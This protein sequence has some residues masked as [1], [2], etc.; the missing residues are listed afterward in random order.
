MRSGKAITALCLDIRRATIEDK[1]PV[2]LRVTYKGERRYYAT[3][4]HLSKD[5]WKSYKGG[6]NRGKLKE[7]R[8]EQPAILNKANNVIEIIEDK[9]EN[10]A[11]S[12]FNDLYFRK[13]EARGGVLE[14]F[15]AYIG[16]FK[17]QGKI[18][19]AQ[20]YQTAKASLETFINKKRI[21]F[22]DITPQLLKSYEKSVVDSG[23]SRSTVGVYLRNLRTIFNKAIQDGVV[24]QEHYPFGHRKY[25]IPSSEA[26]EKALS[27]DVLSILYTY[28]GD[29]TTNEAL[30]KD[31]WFFIYYCN[32]MNVKDVCRLK[33]RNIVRD[34]LSFIRAKTE[35]SVNRV[36]PII[37]PLNEEIT[38]IIGKWGNKPAHPDYYI[39]PFYS[40]VI[41]PEEERRISQN[42]TKM[43]NNHMKKIVKKLEL[44]FDITTYS[45]RHSHSNILNLEGAPTRLI[46]DNLGH[47][48]IHTTEKHYLAAFD[49]ETK[50]K[51]SD[52]LLFFKQKS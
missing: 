17:E 29:E 44:D 14:A 12:R 11:F 37:V 27:K 51:Y 1:Y 31:I 19:S 47:S 24:Q 15:E 13:Q 36:R 25:I 10:F 26:R 16:Q 20:S 35:N 21:A 52:S 23:K 7:L 50:R 2:T 33:Y 18:S 34:S 43:I 28:E 6:S 4:F 49:D 41:T 8:F 30:C 42:L 40:K 39:F 38:R 45:A 3:G 32:G 9:D 22:A 46:A 5:E 48:S